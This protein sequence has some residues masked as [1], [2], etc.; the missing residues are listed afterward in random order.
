[1]ET[2]AAANS[3]LFFVFGK[4]ITEILLGKKN[5]KFKKRK[6]SK[7]PGRWTGNTLFFKGGLGT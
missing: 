7:S 2:R 4:K 1:M 6:K 3:F 5:R